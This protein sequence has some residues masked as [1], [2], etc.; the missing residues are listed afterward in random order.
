[1]DDYFCVVMF[2]Y[3]REYLVLYRDEIIFVCFDDK[4]KLDFGELF[5][6]L[7]FGVRGKK[8]IVFLN[9]MLFCF[10]YDC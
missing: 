6:V 9:L 2:K 8:V 10:D 1:M 3:M 5:L 7:S 4:F